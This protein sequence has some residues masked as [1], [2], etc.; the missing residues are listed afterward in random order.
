MFDI[1]I[2]TIAM[3]VACFS[4]FLLPKDHP[5]RALSLVLICLVF[6]SAGSVVFNLLPALT[7]VYVS[8]I[9][10]IFFLLI[11]AFWLYHDALI[12]VKPWCWDNK[13][14]KHF[15]TVPIAML[16][17]I[18]LL[19]LPE[20]DFKQMFFSSE[21]VSKW[22]LSLLSMLFFIGVLSWCVLSCAYVISILRRTA[23]YQKRIKL[24][25]ADKSGRNLNWIV[26]TSILIVFT[27]VYGLIVLALEDQLLDYGV[28]ETGT[29]ILLAIVVWL[30]A[31]NGIRQ[32]PGF[33]EIQDEPNALNDQTNKKPYERSS[34]GQNDLNRISSKLSV[35]VDRD[36]VHFDSALN[37]PKLSKHIGEPSQYISQT[38]SQQL[39]TTFFDY[40]NTARINEAKE[41]LQSTSNS[42]L[43]I[44]YAIGFN[45]KS[46]FYKAFRQ[47]MDMTPTQYRKSH[48]IR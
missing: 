31:H 47:D 20:E 19:V 34:L 26:I 38:L 3:S 12:S 13:L 6:L 10:S 5:T 35:A 18:A 48:P 33:V 41:L 1:F 21:P 30:V 39:N 28:S 40:I 43:E 37:L 2:S 29:L 8:L 46:S 25:Y 11:P 15:V 45:S 24:V 16:L 32:R 17:G 42:I 4:L 9:P 22:W 44:A 7:Q 36:K 27:W 23:K 14:L